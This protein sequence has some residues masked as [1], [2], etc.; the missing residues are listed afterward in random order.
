MQSQVCLMSTYSFIINL[1]AP[2]L[3]A[4]ITADLNPP[5][6]VGQT[7]HTLTCDVSGA[8]MLSPTIAY[9]WTRNDGST[10]TQVGNLRTLTLPPLTLSSAGEYS[11]HATV[12]SAL[13]TSDGGASIIT[14]QR[15][16]IQSE[17]STLY[18]YTQLV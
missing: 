18:G 16:E 12:S 7:G 14:P 11:C 8:E 9:Q 15:V 2:S 3:I 6:M 4:V 13:L 1:V 17:L 10:Q 5:L